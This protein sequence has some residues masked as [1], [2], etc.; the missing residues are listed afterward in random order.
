MCPRKYCSNIYLSSK[1]FYHFPNTLTYS[2]PKEFREAL[3]EHTSIS[4][5]I[6]TG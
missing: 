4:I 2:T 5:H 6:N 1:F 3:G